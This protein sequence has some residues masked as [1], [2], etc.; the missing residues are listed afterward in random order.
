MQ[1]FRDVLCGEGAVVHQ[2]QLNILDVVDE[3]GLVA[4]GCE[5]AGL[6]V[7]AETDLYRKIYISIILLPPNYHHI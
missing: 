1:I 7:G 2:E 3:E 5:V 4:G 6:L